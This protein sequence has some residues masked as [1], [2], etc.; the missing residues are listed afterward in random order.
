MQ[1]AAFHLLCALLSGGMALLGRRWT[2]KPASYARFFT[3]GAHDG[4]GFA[5]RIARLN[6][7]F[8]FILGSIGVLLYLIMI[9]V[10]LFSLNK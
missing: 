7:W 4:S 9:P 5:G 10:D 6:G 1:I 3:F 2:R 8:F